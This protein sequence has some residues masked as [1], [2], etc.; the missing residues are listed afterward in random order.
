MEQSA[1]T[2]DPDVPTHD[3]FTYCKHHVSICHCGSEG[4]Y[5]NI[6]KKKHWLECF[7][8]RVFRLKERWIEPDWTAHYWR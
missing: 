6:T 2:T 4:Q 8:K 5:H 1:E 7:P 3:I